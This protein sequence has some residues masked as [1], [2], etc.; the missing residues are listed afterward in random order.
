VA[1]T[2]P[3][4]GSAHNS[5]TL[6]FTTGSDVLATDVIW[7]MIG[8]NLTGNTITPP[9]GFTELTLAGG[10]NASSLSQIRIYYNLAPAASTVYNA[11]HGG[12]GRSDLAWIQVRGSVNTS[13]ANHVNT[14]NG[15]SKAVSETPVSDSITTTNA[16]TTLLGFVGFRAFA[17]N[18]VAPG[19]GYT[20]IIDSVGADGSTNI[21]QELASQDVVATGTYTYTATLNPADGEPTII[22]IIALNPSG[23]GTQN[24]AANGIGSDSV[25][26]TPTIA[27]SIT[28]TGVVSAEGLGAARVTPSVSAGAITSAERFGSPSISSTVSPAGLGSSQALGAPTVTAAISAGGIVTAVQLG[29][30]TISTLATISPAGIVSAANVGAA[31]L[32]QIVTPNGVTTGE[33]LGSPT[34][35]VINAINPS[36]IVSGALLGSPTLSTNITISAQGIA[37]SEVVGTAFVQLALVV[38]ANGIPTATA[39]GAPTLTTGP[40]TVSVSGIGST[41]LLGSPSIANITT[42]NANGIPSQ[43]ALSSP[44]F[45]VITAINA[46]GII[47]QSAVGAPAITA[48]VTITAAGIVSSET[49]G[50]PTLY[51]LVQASGIISQQGLGKPTITLGIVTINV[52]GIGSAERFGASLIDA[53]PLVAPAAD[54]LVRLRTGETFITYPVGTTTIRSVGAVNTLISL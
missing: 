51:R 43:E 22:G 39:V 37:S 53:Q 14:S 45:S 2:F 13:L 28:P 1:I 35:S 46:T 12:A 15:G 23:G 9:S 20:E 26:G 48:S 30:P 27:F 47:S 33:Q 32:G 40:V 21:R 18:G 10:N 44:T 5:A 17:I 49:A 36:G 38:N 29:A 42:I 16:S 31:M 3:Y 34:I 6:S 11:T 4:S 54:T 24:V 8:I 52:G 41:E 25:V 19:S 50:T 7:C